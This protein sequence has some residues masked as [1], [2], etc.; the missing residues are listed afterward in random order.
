VSDATGNA[1]STAQTVPPDDF[2]YD[3]TLS[4]A[5][6]NRVYVDEVAAGLRQAGVKV[7]CYTNEEAKGWGEDLADYLADVYENRAR[8][9][10]VFFSKAYAEK[11]WTIYELKSA[12][13]RAFR[14]NARYVFPV[15]FD[16]TP[17]PRSLRGL[18]FINLGKK[19]PQQLV[20]LIVETVLAP[21]QPG[22]IERAKQRK[23]ARRLRHFRYAAA[24][25]LVV[26]ALLWYVLSH[27]HS[28]TTTAVGTAT[29]EFINVRLSNSGWK[30]STPI[31]YR[32]KLDGIPIE[33]LPVER[34]RGVPVDG[35]SVVDLDPIDAHA[36]KDSVPAS[37]SVDI[38]LRPK[39]GELIPQCRDHKYVKL[40]EIQEALRQ[41]R[42][43]L[44]VDVRESDDG[45]EKKHVVGEA[46][47]GK[48][49]DKFIANW[50]VPGPRR[51]C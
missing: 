40:E 13:R 6:D 1:A 16:E 9:C 38:H 15:R 43:T 5:S 41:H 7:F 3:V 24:A 11:I 2:E 36:G 17:I 39:G 46:L 21:E 29:A 20:S 34:M 19:T 14:D 30:P 35:V 8:Y 51:R 32:L 44:E 45:A 37:S 28:H 26:V 31:G 12:Q 25:A 50:W 27:I 49:L 33:G 47:D 4:F 23:K 10:V 42:V 18:K 48:R 22:K